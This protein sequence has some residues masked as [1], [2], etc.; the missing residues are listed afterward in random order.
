M[1]EAVDGVPLVVGSEGGGHSL[2]EVLVVY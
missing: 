2:E 1:L